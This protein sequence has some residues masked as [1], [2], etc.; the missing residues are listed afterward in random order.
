MYKNEVLQSQENQQKIK[1]E[2]KVRG[3][4]VPKKDK[5]MEI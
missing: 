1:K 5:G 4:K 3:V 2:E